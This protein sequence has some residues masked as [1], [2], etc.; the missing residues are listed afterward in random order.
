LT[1][2]FEALHP[3]ADLMPSSNSTITTPIISTTLNEPSSLFIIKTL[4]IEFSKK[5][6][7]EKQIKIEKKEIEKKEIKKLEIEDFKASI[8]F[9]FMEHY[10]Y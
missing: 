2:T 8:L 3:F 4:F 7:I 6:E 1:K 9:F 10:N 5:Q